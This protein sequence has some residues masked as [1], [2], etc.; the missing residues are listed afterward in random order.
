MWGN[1]RQMRKRPF[2]AFDLVLFGYDQ[3]EQMTYSRRENML[4][5]LVEF[6][7]GVL[8]KAA[9]GLG[10][11]HGHGGLFSYDQR[12]THQN[13]PSFTHCFVGRQ[14]SCCVIDVSKRCLNSRGSQRGE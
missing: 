3:F 8:L 1:D 7:R 14:P 9:E 5:A 11:I 10:N 2:A 6:T 4:I 13:V 12:F